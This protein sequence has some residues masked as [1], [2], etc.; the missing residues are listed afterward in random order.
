MILRILFA[1]LLILLAPHAEARFTTP[2]YNFTLK[3]MPEDELRS[4]LNWIN[5]RMQNDFGPKMAKEF[6]DKLSVQKP[7]LHPV[8]V[9]MMTDERKDAYFKKSAEDLVK[10]TKPMRD[11][12]IMFIIDQFE[13]VDLER[14]KNFFEAYPKFA[15]V[16]M[17]YDHYR[18]LTYEVHAVFT[19]DHRKRWNVAADIAVMLLQVKPVYIDFTDEKVEN[20]FT[21]NVVN[22]LTNNFEM[23]QLQ[24]IKEFMGSMTGQ[25]YLGI[26]YRLYG[27]RYH[28]LQEVYKKNYPVYAEP[29][30]EKKSGKEFE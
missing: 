8:D 5:Y 4:D 2:K 22:Y 16:L 3:L 18:T 17:N 15:N 14:V 23:K 9:G 7:T 26:L 24:I 19:T 21:N 25:K 10:I 27:N 29:E 28:A 12:E 13:D 1:C 11:R 6:A 20:K 30:Q